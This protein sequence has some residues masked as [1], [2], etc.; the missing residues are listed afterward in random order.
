MIKLS[1]YP[2]ILLTLVFLAFLNSC[3][4]KPV[5]NPGSIQLSGIKANN[6]PLDLQGQNEGISVDCSLH[7]GFTAAVDQGS[8]TENILLQD[9][10]GGR[11]DCGY[12]F[13]DDSK[14]V[15]LVPVEPLDYYAGYTIN[16]KSTLKGATGESFPGLEVVFTTGPGQFQ[17]LSITLN[18]RRRSR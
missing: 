1:S 8:A 2:V 5:E 13:S 6:S 12:S 16:I 10:Q 9:T 11:V 14:T 7:V 17:L 4:D 15:T 3:K 18:A